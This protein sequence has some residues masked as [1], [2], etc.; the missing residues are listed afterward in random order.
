M[1][2]VVRADCVFAI[3]DDA[4]VESVFDVAALFS[5]PK[6][7]SV[8]VSLSVNRNGGRLARAAKCIVRAKRVPAASR[9][10]PCCRDLP[11]RPIAFVVATPAPGIAEP[12]GGQDVNVGRSPDRDSRP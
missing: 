9:F 3:V 6:S 11:F 8:L 2:D 5:K 4:L 10:S 7:R 12:D 1:P